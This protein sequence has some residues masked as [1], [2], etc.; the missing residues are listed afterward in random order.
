[1]D[2]IDEYLEFFRKSMVKNEVFIPKDGVLA[3][4]YAI[5]DMDEK[6]WGMHEYDNFHFPLGDAYF[7][8]GIPGIIQKIENTH[9]D[10][11]DLK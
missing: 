5:H 1:M 6:V 11:W 8:Y 9:Y 4:D 3:G 2:S 10:L 7:Q